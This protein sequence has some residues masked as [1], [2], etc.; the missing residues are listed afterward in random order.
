MDWQ[1]FSLHS[2]AESDG[3]E[4]LGSVRK[5]KRA[6]VFE[7][8]QQGRKSFLTA[9]SAEEEKQDQCQVAVEVERSQQGRKSF[10]DCDVSRGGAAGSVSSCRG[11]GCFCSTRISPG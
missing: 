5:S 9:T 6:R 2:D 10:S 1:H 3:S 11:S 8:S 4:D 7:R